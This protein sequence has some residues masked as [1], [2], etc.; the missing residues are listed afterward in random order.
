MHNLNNQP[1]VIKSL[2]FNYLTLKEL[3]VIRLLDKSFDKFIR[4]TRWDKFM[5]YIN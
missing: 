1:K 4:E 3:M 2:I 5:I